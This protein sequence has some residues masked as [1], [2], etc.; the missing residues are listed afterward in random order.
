M[1]EAA[2]GTAR[3]AA[4][5]EVEA[6]LAAGATATARGTAHATRRVLHT[7]SHRY[8][9]VLALAIV[10]FLDEVDAAALLKRVAV[11][12]RR[13]VAEDVLAAIVR[14]DEPETTLAPTACDAG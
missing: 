6:H 12:D 2:R 10:I 13:E 7:A 1:G 8:C 4:L 3:A 9:A 5:L 11:L 14:L